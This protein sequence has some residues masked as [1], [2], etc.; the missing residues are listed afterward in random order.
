[1]LAV[2]ELTPRA[3]ARLRGGGVERLLPAAHVLPAGPGKPAAASGAVWSRRPIT[4]RSAAAGS[5]EQPTARL[6][7]AGAAVEVTAVHTKPP[8]LS[9]AQVRA[10]TADLARLPTPDRDVLRV[11]AGDFNATPDHAA[12][13]AVVSAGY[14]DAAAAV[15]RG[16]AW[17]WQPLRLRRPR[18]TLDHVLVDPRIR[19]V[20]VEFVRLRG[21]DHRSVVVDLELPPPG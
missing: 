19:V 8:A 1:V 14:V 13:R 6:E 20:G 2:A 21:S 9:P 11:L 18:L 3:L 7:T 17:T 4:A 15:G 16:R 5:F 10:W 12:L